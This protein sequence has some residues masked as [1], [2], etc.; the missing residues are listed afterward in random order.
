M[1]HANSI[2]DVECTRVTDGLSG[3]HD[4]YGGC[5]AMDHRIVAC[6]DDGTM[7]AERRH[8]AGG[9]VVESV[10]LDC[11]F[12]RPGECVDVDTCR[13]VPPE[14][15]VY[16][17]PGSFTMG[18]DDETRC[19]PIEAPAHEVTL[20]R[21]LFVA[22]T[23]LGDVELARARRDVSVWEWLEA[24]GDVRS[25]VRSADNF[26]RPAYPYYLGLPD[27]SY[28]FWFNTLSERAGLD[29][30]FAGNHLVDGIASGLTHPAEC[31]GYR[32]PTE[33]EWEYFA[34]A[35]TTGPT[36]IDLEVPPDASCED[37]LAS[38]A[39]YE[40][41]RCREVW[42][43]PSPVRGA[44]QPNPFGLYDTLGNPSEIVFDSA[45]P[46]PFDEQAEIDPWGGAERAVRG[47]PATL[48]LRASAR[49]AFN[50]VERR[51]TMRA[52]R[53]APPEADPSWEPERD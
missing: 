14:G 28:G 4:E 50:S 12:C 43:S 7:V 1:G 30:C 9:L 26:E 41:L 46:V 5:T 22:T 48:P 37:Q 8:C 45:V 53:T 3:W 20:T 15:F 18:C 19:E 16:V 36:W 51:N 35:G 47:N 13:I 39:E 33:A 40:R 23:E 25:F 34:R 32:P 24:G 49:S 11:G 6:N 31:S 10:T 44:L 21:G 17:P 27:Q 38:F 52:V 42:E 2:H 29:S